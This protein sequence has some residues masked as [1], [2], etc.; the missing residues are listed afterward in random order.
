[1]KYLFILFLITLSS[2]SNSISEKKETM[3]DKSNTWNLVSEI[4]VDDFILFNWE[5]KYWTPTATEWYIKLIE[6]K[7][8]IQFDKT[9]DKQIEI[10]FSD[11]VFF[12]G[13]KIK[14]NLLNLN[15]EQIYLFSWQNIFQNW[16]Q[17]TYIN[18]IKTK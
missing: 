12:N 14:N 18:S 6:S 17:I 13:E 3:N 4:K 9:I 8:Y 15:T 1:M 2:C 16:N 7:Y 5:K 10:K 11:Y